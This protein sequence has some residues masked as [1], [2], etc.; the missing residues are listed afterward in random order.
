MAEGGQGRALLVVSMA[1][2]QLSHRNLFRSFYLEMHHHQIVEDDSALVEK[3]VYITPP[4]HQRS[5]V[6]AHDQENMQRAERKNVL[7]M[8]SICFGRAARTLLNERLSYAKN[9]PQKQGGFL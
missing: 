2:P 3:V 1:S 5:I 9:A 6:P 8:A 4:E 7:R